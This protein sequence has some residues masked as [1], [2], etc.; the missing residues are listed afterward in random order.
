MQGLIIR[1]WECNVLQG[2]LNGLQ[3]HIRL[4]GK[5]HMDKTGQGHVQGRGHKRSVTR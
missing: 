4:E 5:Y 2:L 1:A 3:G